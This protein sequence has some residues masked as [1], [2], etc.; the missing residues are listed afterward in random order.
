MQGYETDKI[1]KIWETEPD[2]Q[3]VYVL[4]LSSFFTHVLFFLVIQ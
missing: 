1:R 3:N 2:E 4:K